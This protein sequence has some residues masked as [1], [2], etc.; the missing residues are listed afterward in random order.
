MA[1]WGAVDDQGQS[2]ELCR[3]FV[4]KIFSSP[5]P[6]TFCS[7]KRVE[8]INKN[9]LQVQCSCCGRPDPEEWHTTGWVACSA[10]GW[11]EP[12]QEPHTLVQVLGHRSR[13]LDHQCHKA[14]AHS[15]LPCAFL[16]GCE[17]GIPE[18]RRASKQDPQVLANSQRIPDLAPSCL[19][20][21][22]EAGLLPLPPPSF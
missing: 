3:S 8:Q 2:G 20:L 21:S 22:G 17:Q 19:P 6:P 18:A 15:W 14:P 12:L 11:G 4:R 7:S 9:A 1:G 5:P 13:V 16:P 10:G